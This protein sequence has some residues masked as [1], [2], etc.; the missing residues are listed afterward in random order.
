MLSPLQLEI[1]PRI[2]LEHETVQLKHNPDA[3]KLTCV[4][5][6]IN[7]SLHAETANA[8]KADFVLK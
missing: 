5:N 6:G 8:F 1:P 7:E 4:E 3:M 2:S